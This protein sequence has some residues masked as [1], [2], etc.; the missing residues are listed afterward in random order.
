MPVI[1]YTKEQ[2]R[3]LYDK[4]KECTTADERDV[5]IEAF[6]KQHNK[7][8]RS[9]TAKLSSMDIY[10]PKTKIS[11]VTGIEPETKKQVVE[12]IEK[13]L[14]A[15]SQLASLEKASKLTLMKLLGIIL[16]LSE[17]KE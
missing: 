8:K 16:E 15:P 12:K 2:E 3:E 6:E 17:I 4:Y 11:K 13:L 10:V 9:I 5:V 7:T 14:N 1:K